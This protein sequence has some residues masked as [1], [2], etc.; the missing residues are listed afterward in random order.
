MMFP[1]TLPETVRYR[2]GLDTRHG[3]Q[4]HLLGEAIND[5]HDI[6]GVPL[7]LRRQ[8]GHKIDGYLMPHPIRHRKGLQESSGLISPDLRCS[9]DKAIMLQP[10]HILIRTRPELVAY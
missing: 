10:T 2:F 9:T 7:F 3:L 5:D 4:N 1:K 6:C 8:I